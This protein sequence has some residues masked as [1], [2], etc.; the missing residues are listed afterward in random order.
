VQQ[1]P[2][3]M[4]SSD[5][6]PDPPQQTERCPLTE[7]V[8]GDV[9][10]DEEVKEEPLSSS[11]PRPPQPLASAQRS[12]N[13]DGAGDGARGVGGEAGEE[14]E[15]QQQ[16]ARL[17]RRDPRLRGAARAAA[18][19]GHLPAPAVDPTAAAAEPPPTNPNENNTTTLST[20]FGLNLLALHRNFVS[21]LW[22]RDLQ[23]FATLH[24]PETK[25]G[26][27]REA[28]PASPRQLAV[29]LPR[30]SATWS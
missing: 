2:T 12:D 13:G 9:S 10:H 7:E 4:H 22:N 18:T 19:P 26:F 16:Q 29:G 25:E 24:W 17:S 14:A 28:R 1:K 6:D 11:P 23:G 20:S 21:A 15:H 27:S 30:G 8:E 5:H 3:T